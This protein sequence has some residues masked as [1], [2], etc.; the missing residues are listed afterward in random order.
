M[1]E[2][3][4]MIALTG[5]CARSFQYVSS[6]HLHSSL[7]K[8]LRVREVRSQVTCPGMHSQ[9][10]AEPRSLWQQDQMAFHYTKSTP[11]A[12]P[13]KEFSYVSETVLNN[14]LVLSHLTFVEIHIN[15][16]TLPT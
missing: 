11:E 1:D 13:V 4:L 14:F 10:L 8:K 12:W 6:F 5:Y 9:P 7:I 3:C 15:I 16:L 2:F